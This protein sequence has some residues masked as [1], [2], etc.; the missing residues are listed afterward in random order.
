MIEIILVVAITV[1]AILNPILVGISFYVGFKM[2]KGEP[3]IPRR[4]RFKFRND[5]ELARLEAEK[6]RTNK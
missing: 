6:E 2:S 5:E 3:I 1:L 4:M